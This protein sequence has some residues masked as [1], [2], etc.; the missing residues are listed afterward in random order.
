[1]GN[2]STDS[3]TGLA[4][5]LLEPT[6]PILFLA[7]PAGI[8]FQV[9]AAIKSNG[10]LRS[11]SGTSISGNAGLGVEILGKVPEVEI[12]LENRTVLRRKPGEGGVGP[13]VF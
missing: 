7:L 1:M 11:S 8:A 13:L 10:T 3:S 4:R 2:S 5:L 9:I 6:V 12:E